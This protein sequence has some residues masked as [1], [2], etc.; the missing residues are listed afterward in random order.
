VAISKNSG[1]GSYRSHHGIMVSARR[2]KVAGIGM[3][4]AA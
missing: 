2:I 1:G 4:L 3:A